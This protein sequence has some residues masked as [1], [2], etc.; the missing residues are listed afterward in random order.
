M[1]SLHLKHSGS[2]QR[3]PYLE[4]INTGTGDNA[5][6]IFFKKD[7]SDPTAN[8]KMG[9]IVLQC[10]DSSGGDPEDFAEISFISSNVSSGSEA[11]KMVFKTRTGGASAEEVLAVNSNTVDV[12]GDLN[13][14]GRI[15]ITSEQSNEPSLTTD[16]NGYIYSKT[17]GKLYWKSY[18]AS[19]M[20]L[21]AAGVVSLS[22]STDNTICTVTGA[23]AIQ[24]EANL[25]FDGTTLSN[26][27]GKLNLE[28]TTTGGT[29]LSMQQ[30]DNN[31]DAPNFKIIKSRQPTGSNTYAPLQYG[32]RIFSFNGLGAISTGNVK[33][34][35]QF[36]F[37][38]DGTP[39]G[40]TVNSGG[41]DVNIP[42]RILF[43]TA[44]ESDSS[45]ITRLKIDKNGHIYF[46]TDSVNINFGADSEIQLS[47]NADTGLSLNGDFTSNKVGVGTTS[48]GTLLQ[49]EGTEPYITLK[50]TSSENT[51]GGDSGNSYTGC[52]SRIIFEDH[53]NNELARLQGNHDG[54]SDDTK[55]DLIFFTNNGT[56]ITEGFRLNSSG[57]VGIG[58][59]APTHK[60]DVT[61]TTRFLGNI[62]IGGFL[63]PRLDLIFDGY[64][65]SNSNGGTINYTDE[66]CYIIQT[67][68]SLEGSLLLPAN[69]SDANTTSDD[70]STLA[71][72]NLWGN[73]DKN[74]LNVYNISSSGNVTLSGSLSSGLNFFGIIGNKSQTSAFTRT[75]TLPT[76][77]D[78]SHV[79]VVAVNIRL[80]SP[81]G[82]Y[83]IVQF[84]CPSAVDD[85]SISILA[86]TPE[87]ATKAAD[88]NT[89]LRIEK[90]Y[91]NTTSTGE[92][93][94]NVSGYIMFRPNSSGQYHVIS[95][96][97]AYSPMNV[98]GGYWDD[99]LSTKF[100]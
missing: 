9:R 37:E 35:A 44:T 85:N 29:L 41:T 30:K 83:M 96:L 51:D 87:V 20:D 18:G 1:E 43:N 19:E 94:S 79:I 91:S 76:P 39:T 81:G 90:R 28:S 47:H 24:G 15:K 33:I 72:R 92:S 82:N 7:S 25:T 75:Y 67:I 98:P 27:G 36:H 16:G 38:V 53:A 34:G 56:A 77:S 54:T 58:Q 61:G 70:A 8:D 66:Y 48:P 84:N 13:L 40:T 21:T 73:T 88:T 3:A 95:A 59:I 26:T 12:S 60:L 69:L 2:S 74:Y 49:V 6:A 45:S 23:S 55:G 99:I 52:E 22:G 5:G 31:D 42:T 14:E 46:P 68:P 80:T 89:Y 50:N 63:K 32:D 71:L 86:N 100:L 4:F 97:A 62:T 57:N 10:A 64:T 65:A 78:N 11:S 17:D 93:T